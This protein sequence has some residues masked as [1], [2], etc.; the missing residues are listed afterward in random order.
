MQPP[1]TLG[2]GTHCILTLW[3]PPLGLSVYLAWLIAW[4]PSLTLPYTERGDGA[5]WEATC[6]F[7]SNYREQGER[8]CL[9]LYMCVCN[10]YTLG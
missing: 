9:C 7:Q 1:V 5:L 2:L 4:T 10:I 3:L 6:L 8:M